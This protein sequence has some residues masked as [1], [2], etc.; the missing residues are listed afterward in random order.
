MSPDSLF[1]WL[2]GTAPATAIRENAHLF[3]LI[4]SIHVV[5]ITLVFG[6]IAVVDLRLLCL[7][8]LESRISR[9]TRGLLPWTWLAFAIAVATGSLLFSSN[10]T[11]YGHN[12]Y[13][14]SKLVLMLAAGVN[15]TVFHFFGSRDLE[16]WDAL[17]STPLR[18][19]LAGAISLLL[20]IG[21]IACGRWIGF[22]M[23][24]VF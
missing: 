10:A 18:A 2:E 13:F 5:A 12:F 24:R 9:L 19:R 4:E 23:L 11:A 15:M 20:W 3:P 6:T 1:Q 16:R 8:S 22:T 14:Q 17:P 7:A 21:V